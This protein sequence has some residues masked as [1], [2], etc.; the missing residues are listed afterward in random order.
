M[1]PDADDPYAAVRPY[2]R[3]ADEVDPD[4]LAVALAAA[5]HQCEQFAPP[6]PA[7][8][9]LPHAWLLAQA[10]Q[11]RALTASGNVGPRDQYGAEDL[12][13]HVFPMD[14]TVKALLRPPGRVVVR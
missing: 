2:W 7:D 8:D 14:W 13:V 6:V 1:D 9:A 3:T 11:A 12:T 10:M 4:T 5:A